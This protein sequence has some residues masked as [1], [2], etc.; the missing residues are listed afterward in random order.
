MKEG[1]ILVVRALAGAVAAAILVMGGASLARAGEAPAKKVEL[2]PR[3][4]PDVADGFASVNAMGQ[5]GTTGGAGGY[6]VTVTNQADLERYAMVPDP[7]IIRVKGTIKIT[8]KPDPVTYY[9]KMTPKEVHV[10]S[11]KTIIGVGTTGEIVNGGFFLRPGTHNV[12]IRNLTIRDTYVKGDW[13]GKTQDDDGLQMDGAHHVWVDHCHFTRHGDGCIDSRLGTT[14]L[15]VSWCIFSNHN[16]TFGMGWH[17]PVTSQNTLHHN[18]FR[19]TACRNPRTGGCLRL[20]LYNNFLQDVGTRGQWAG[21]GTH[22]LIENS[23]YENVTNPHYARGAGSLVVTGNVYRNCRG[24]RDTRG[25]ATFDPA[26]FY[27]YTLDKAKDLPAILA[28]YAGPQ[29][30]IGAPR[31]AVTPKGKVRPGLRYRYYE[32]AMQ[33]CGDL[34]GKKAVKQGVIGTPTLEIEGRRKDKF[35]VVY[36]GHIKV[37]EDGLYR[38]SAASDDGSILWLDDTPVVDND[39]THSRR[40]RAGTVSL[41]AGYHKIRIA[42]FDGGGGGHLGVFWQPPGGKR[43]PLPAGVLFHTE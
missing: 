30:N 28:K 9:E 6:V 1:R 26:K 39:G 43:Q 5:N 27:K 21:E 29:E 40:E 12:I 41:A 15:T 18:W 3:E 20:H 38:F 31:P 24:S 37:S 13:I 4:W 23:L 11:D 10:A 17:K 14:Y 16:K 33:R 8:P 34:E 42:F 36:E 35:G 19:E 2:P 32:A 22:M 7:C 25:S